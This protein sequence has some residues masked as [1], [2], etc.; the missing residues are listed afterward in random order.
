MCLGRLA[1]GPSSALPRASHL[2]A[3]DVDRVCDARGNCGVE[4]AVFRFAGAGGVVTQG[5]VIDV[6]LRCQ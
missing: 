4:Q 2:N 1:W 3:S 5:R 6:H